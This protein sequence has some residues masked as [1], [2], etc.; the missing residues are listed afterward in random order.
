MNPE[1]IDR[2]LANRDQILAYDSPIEGMD[3][4]GNLCD[5]RIQIRTTIQDAIN[6]VRK[7]YRKPPG[8]RKMLEDFIAVNWAYEPK[9]TPVPSGNR[10]ESVQQLIDSALDE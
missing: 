8:D 7:Y 1:D 2:L 5:C 6:Q 9:P 3:E 10:Y 4:H